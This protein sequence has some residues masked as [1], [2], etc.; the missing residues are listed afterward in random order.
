MAKGIPVTEKEFDKIKTLIESNVPL[1][2]IAQLAK[3]DLSTIIMM[4]K[5]ETFNPYTELR[6]SIN[7]KKSA[8]KMHKTKEPKQAEKLAAGSDDLKDLLYGMNGIYEKLSLLIGYAR[9]TASLMNQ[10]V[11]LWRK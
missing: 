3:R 10:L 1:K 4:Q 7:A 6:K 11:E 5:C 9:E 8:Y 2:M